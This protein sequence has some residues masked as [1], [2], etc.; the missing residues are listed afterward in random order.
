MEHQ[1]MTWLAHF[2]VFLSLLPSQALAQTK[3]P[4]SYSLR[5]YGFILTISLMGGFVNWYTKVRKG[6]TPLSLMALVGELATSAL[7]GVLVFYV[8]EWMTL[9]PL[10]TAAIVGIVGHMGGRAI[11]WAEAKLQQRAE[12]IFLDSVKPAERKD[13]PKQ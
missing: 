11:A 2:A 12:S 4:L 7:A 6:E 10:L 8:C 3:D 5:Q 1:S 13:E 9:A